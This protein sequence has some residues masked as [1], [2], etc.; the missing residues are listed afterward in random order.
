MDKSVD[1][2]EQNKWFLSASFRNWKYI[3]FVDSQTPRSIFSIL[4]YA[5]WTLSRGYNIEKMRGRW[6]VRLGDWKT[7]ALNE[8]GGFF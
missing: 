7:D 6:N 5:P 3:F 1:T 4:K 2:L 8:T